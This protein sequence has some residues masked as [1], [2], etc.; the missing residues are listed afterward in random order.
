MATQ[1]L[2]N[3]SETL[4]TRQTLQP[5][6]GR[7]WLGGFGNML[8]K[9]VGEWFGTRRWLWQA[10]I[11]LAMINGLMAFVM[12]VVPKIDP[13]GMQDSEG[14]PIGKEE[15]LALGLSLY[16]S[17]A[18]IAG[19]IGVVILAQD[20]VIRE[21]QSGTAAWTLSKPASR[22]GFI[23]TKV[24]SNL[25]GVL[26]FIIVLPGLVAYAL[27]I[28]ATG[29]TTNPLAFLA[30]AG[31]VYL[32]LVF[33]ICLTIML[34]VIFEQRG[35]VLGIAFGLMFGGLMLSAFVPGL[36]YILPLNMDKISVAAVQ[37]Q[38]LPAAAIAQLISTALLSILFTMIALWRFQQEEL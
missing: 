7:G 6:R 4:N 15:V 18:T 17:M 35:P 10:I 11:W 34:G 38:D 23:L 14:A 31:V 9:E 13:A 37:G 22:T 8:D 20:E 1:S 3:S 24:I 36:T 26:I 33:Y 28:L 5:T 29:I 12:F 2:S 27:V 16:F 25:L 19:S 21:K 30:G 32:A